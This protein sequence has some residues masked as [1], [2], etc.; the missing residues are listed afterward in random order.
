MLRSVAFVALTGC[1]FALVKGPSPYPPPPPH[2]IRC[3]TVPVAPV[4]D[5]VISAVALGGVIYFAQ[6]DIDNASI[7]AAFEAMIAAGFG[8]SAYTG[9]KRVS[10]CRAVKAERNQP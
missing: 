4:I 6:S 8:I 10:R 3:T 1:S 5:T 2:P 7:G 9:W